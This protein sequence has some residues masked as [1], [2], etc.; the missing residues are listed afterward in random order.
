MKEVGPATIAGQPTVEFTA[1]V[2]IGSLLSSFGAELVHA[3]EAKDITTAAY[4]LYIAPDGLPVRVED[5]IEAN[6]DVLS[7][8]YTVLETN[9]PVTVKAPPARRVISLAEFK[10]VER[11]H[12]KK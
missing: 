4:T 7:A 2:D 6:G 10:R 9:E 11:K 5:T 8:T 3:L 1:T 12:A